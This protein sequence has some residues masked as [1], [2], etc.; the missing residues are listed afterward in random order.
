MLA[1]NGYMTSF[2]VQN[3]KKNKKNNYFGK[4][5]QILGELSIKVKIY[6]WQKHNTVKK[7]YK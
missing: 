4:K 1:Q 5:K 3:F 2:T 6:F 7:V